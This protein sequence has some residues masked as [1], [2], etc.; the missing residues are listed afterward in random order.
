MKVNETAIR[1]LATYVYE[2]KLY[3][4]NIHDKILRHSMFINWQKFMKTDQKYAA[5]LLSNWRNLYFW[6]EAPSVERNMIHSVIDC[7]VTLMKF[8]TLHKVVNRARY[9]NRNNLSSV[10]NLW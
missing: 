10:E 8:V 5:A 2:R 1:G 4:G 9:W 6:N 7:V 3:R